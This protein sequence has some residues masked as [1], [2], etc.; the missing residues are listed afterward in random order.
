M[1][2]VWPVAA[3]IVAALVVMA[4]A[5]PA[6]A[7]ERAGVIMPNRITAGGKTLYLRGMGVHEVTIF[8]LDVFVAGL[9]LEQ[10]NTPRNAIVGSDQI[11]V[12][13]LHFKRGV[14]RNRLAKGVFSKLRTQLGERAYHR[15]GAQ[16]SK[17]ASLI[18]SF[19]SGDTF[20]ICRY[21]GHGLLVEVNGRSR[22][23]V[24]ST[25]LAQSVFALW[26]G[27]HP[28]SEGLKRDLLGRR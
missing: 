9:Y 18:P 12:L 22:G 2:Q 17:L 1:K 3:M 20:T 8:R 24:A 25:Q 16:I 26:L 15:L 7:S 13:H 11:E 21:P 14:S 5:P 27:R 19:N 6:R 4:A 28:F 10:P 23:M